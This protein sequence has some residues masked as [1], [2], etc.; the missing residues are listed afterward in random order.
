MRVLLLTFILILTP[1]VQAASEAERQSLNIMLMEL[2]YIKNLL[3]EAEGNRDYK[4]RHVFN[5]K[6]TNVVLDAIKDDVKGHLVLP[7]AP[8]PLLVKEVPTNEGL[9]LACLKP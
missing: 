1:S 5:Y 6:Q 8:R 4:D 3:A 7:V 9:F 2:E